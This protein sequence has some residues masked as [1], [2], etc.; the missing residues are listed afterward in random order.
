MALLRI[1]YFSENRLGFTSRNQRLRA[2]QAEAIAK[3]AAARL[4]GALAH[5]DLWFVQ[6][7]E[8]EEAVVNAT[9]D[10]ILRDRRHA[11]VSIVSKSLVPTRLFGDWS[12]GFAMRSSRNEHLFGSHWN[13]TGLNPKSM[14]ADTIVKLLQALAAE[15]HMSAKAIRNMAA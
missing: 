12:M 9:F 4:S 14:N 8:G 2:L 1:A 3:N 13:N 10:R 11:N 7:L 5:D 15:G 6:V